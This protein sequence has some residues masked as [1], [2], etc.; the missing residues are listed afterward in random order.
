MKKFIL[1]IILLVVS[2]VPQIAAPKQVID[3]IFL[4]MAV[5]YDYVDENQFTGTVVAPFYKPDKTI[6][7]LA[8]SNTSS[9][10]Y[11]NRDKLEAESSKPLLSGKLQVVLYNR[12]LAEKNGILR[13]IDSL[14]R[15]PNVGSRIKLAIFD[16][17]TENLFH[18]L[19]TDEPT[20]IYISNLLDENTNFSNLPETNLHTFEFSYYVKGMDPFLPLL[21]KR[22]NRVKVKGMALFKKDKMVDLVP[23]Q[24]LF[25]L[26][27]M[28]Q[29]FKKGV[30]FIKLDNR[31]RALLTN[32][33]SSRKFDIKH[34][35]GGLPPNITINIKF[36]GIIREYSG[37]YIPDKY[38][39]DI[40]KQIE[41][42][43]EKK[44]KEMLLSF[45]EMGIDPVGIGYQVRHHTRN[46][47]DENWS[48]IYPN[49]D[50]KVKADV[51]ILER[52]V[53]K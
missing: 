47:N 5:G 7:N 13:Y 43:I 50:I 34:N 35:K 11:Q 42:N 2:M 49:V 12:E 14:Q 39:N 28:V 24:E 48:E 52:G 20:G 1:F 36:K 9:L 40:E 26:R 4:V 8:F 21:E 29:D 6:E 22:D 44:T 32:V 3:E 15:D 53:I 19:K 25:Y 23:Q 38:I 17:S 27:S 30:F 46:Y 41:K 31:K 45:Q 33:A 10:I 51:S 37:P 16:G 18:K